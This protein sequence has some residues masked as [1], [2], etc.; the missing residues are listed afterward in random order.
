M[1]GGCR[2]MTSVEFAAMHRSCE[3]LKK[4]PEQALTWEEVREELEASAKKQRLSR[5]ARPIKRRRRVRQYSWLSPP[6]EPSKQE[7]RRRRLE[8]AILAWRR[9]LRHGL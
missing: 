7:R 5:K 3:E 4:H 6:P 2:F 1:P 9:R 8:R